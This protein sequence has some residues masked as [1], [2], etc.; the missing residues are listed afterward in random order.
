MFKITISNWLKDVVSTDSE[1]ELKKPDVLEF[2][3]SKKEFD[4]YLS[5][6]LLVTCDDNLT[7]S[8]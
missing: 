5:K 6:E 2:I 3:K 8:E 1:G 4:R 7:F